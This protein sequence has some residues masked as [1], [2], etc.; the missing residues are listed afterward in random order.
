MEAQVE[1]L[2]QEVCSL[3]EQV[4]RERDALRVKEKQLDDQGQTIRQLKEA[5]ADRES[6]VQSV[7]VEWESQQRGLQLQL[8][9]EEAASHDLQV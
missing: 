4:Q 2:S 5:L 6:E 3:R 9:Q 1:S 8:E 7:R